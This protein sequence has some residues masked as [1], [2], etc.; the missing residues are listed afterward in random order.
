[1]HDLLNDD[2]AIVYVPD[3]LYIECTNILWKKVQR[4]EVD[5]QTAEENLADLAA[6]GLNATPIADLM[7]SAL[8]LA[9]DYNISAYDACYVALAAQ[10]ALPLLT[11][12]DPLANKLAGSPHIILRLSSLMPL[13]RPPLP[14]VS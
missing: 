3:L 9:C 7:A 13:L 6:M 12:D 1:M 8:R 11:A 2:D 5:R 14:P 10:Q 4:G